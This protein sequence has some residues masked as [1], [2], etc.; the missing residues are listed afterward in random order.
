MLSSDQTESLSGDTL[1]Q[2]SA[3]SKFRQRP[4]FDVRVTDDVSRIAQSWY[5]ARNT[6]ASSNTETGQMC[7]L[8]TDSGSGSV[9][10]AR[11][12]LR[13]QSGKTEQSLLVRCHCCWHGDTYPLFVLQHLSRLPVNAQHRQ[14]PL[15]PAG[16]NYWIKIL[17]YGYS[18]ALYCFHF[19][20]EFN[21]QVY[22]Y[23]KHT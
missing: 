7:K 3:R 1:R 5:H 15:R 19:V 13:E 10:V 22:R 23:R 18:L 20:Y 9:V 16:C 21:S 6:R 12:R 14:R 8:H 17:Q 4:H 2:N 11:R